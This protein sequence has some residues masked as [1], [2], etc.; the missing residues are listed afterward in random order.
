MIDWF[1]YFSR[2]PAQVKIGKSTYQILWVV[3]FPKD[4]EQL[5][6]SRFDELKQ[7]IIKIGQSNKESVH[8]YWHECLHAASEEY[9]IGLTENQ[10]LKLEKFLPN[11]LK[12]GNLWMKAGKNETN[13]RKRRNLKRV[14]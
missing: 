4:K 9:E 1:K 3:E 6:E 5:G 14:R 2:I 11:I 7:I 13:K 10:V 8:T 12:N